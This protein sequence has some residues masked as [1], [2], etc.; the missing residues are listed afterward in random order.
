[1][2]NIWR[3]PYLAQVNGGGTF[4]IP[5]FIS[6]FI[7][8]L[9]ILTL[10]LSIGQRLRKGAS[11]AYQ[12]FHR[13]FAG[14]GIGMMVVSV[15]VGLYYNMIVGWALYYFMQSFQGIIFHK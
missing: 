13:G 15:F 8:G 2:G 4:L 14:V 12:L 1:M 9:P 11:G 6:L 7:I 10:E 3:F 5:Y